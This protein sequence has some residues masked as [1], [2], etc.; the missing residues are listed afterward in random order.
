MFIPQHC[1]NTYGVLGQ[2]MPGKEEGGV[3]EKEV[4]KEAILACIFTIVS[5]INL[6]VA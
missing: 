2:Y 4:R 3:S 6:M 1:S 5:A